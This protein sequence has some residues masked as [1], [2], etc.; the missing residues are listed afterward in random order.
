MRTDLDLGEPGLAHKPT[1]LGVISASVQAMTI[2]YF[3]NAYPKVSHT[4]IR[5][6]IEMLEKLGQTVHRF[7]LRSRSSEIV[8]ASD[9]RERDR[10]AFLLDG[11]MASL[12][13]AIPRMAWV[14]PSGVAAALRLS[15]IMMWRSNRSVIKH[16]VTLCEA[17]ELA[18][19]VRAA[20][21]THIH[22]HF[23]TNSAEVAMLASAIARVPFSFTVHGP[24]E[25]DCPEFL[26]LWLKVSRAKFVA[27]I[28][29]FGASQ[30][31]R[32]AKP[33]DWGKVQV[34]RCGLDPLMFDEPILPQVDRPHFVSIARL[35]AQKGHLLMLQAVAE[36]RRRG[37]PIQL[38]LIGD[39]E[40]HQAVREAIAFY[41]LGQ[42]VR[43]AG[44]LSE[45]EVRRAINEARA[46]L[47]PSFAEGLPVVLMEAMALGRPVLASNVAAIPDLVNA[48]TGWLF[49]PGSVDA[50]VEA[51]TACLSTSL[52]TRTQMG[53][54]ARAAV[55]A[56]QDLSV[57][58]KTLIGLI[59]AADVP[60]PQCRPAP[61][62]R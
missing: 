12:L 41:D 58:V 54:A 22:A 38:T 33:A 40:L 17:A 47:L 62:Q 18:R 8:D 13:L 30:I 21:L 60:N 61:I 57:Q 24:D 29:D 11:G 28:S 9:E 52:A 2:G 14:H 16:V 31:Y 56:K 20:G 15:L 37:Q 44:W 49:T 53:E 55:R 43:M 36:L 59:E 32:W 27:A 4:F 45:A 1:D 26:K 10:T 7:A 34:V 23:G 3:V 35:S 46:L 25:F 42:S 6:E 39:G 48:Q 5:R 51:V 19:R 50:I